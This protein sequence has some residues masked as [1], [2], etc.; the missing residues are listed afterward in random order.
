MKLENSLC[1]DLFHINDMCTT[2]A[3]LQ[4]EKWKAVRDLEMTLVISQNEIHCP[5]LSKAIVIPTEV[6]NG[7]REQLKQLKTE[8]S[9]TKAHLR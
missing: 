5:D 6:L 2:I 8:I 9:A 4:K 3:M 1:H 7:T